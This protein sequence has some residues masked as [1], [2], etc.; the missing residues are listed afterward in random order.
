MHALLLARWQF[1]ITTVYH[2]LFVPL[3][4]GTAFLTA[5]LQTLWLHSGEQRHLRATKFWGRIFL[6]GFVLGV[7]TGIVRQFQLGMAWSGSSRFVGDALGAP[8]AIEGLLA[9]F[10]ESTFL[11]LWVLG[12]DRL[13]RSLHTACIWIAACATALSAY[14]VLAVEG[15][16]RHPVGYTLD[17]ARHVARLTS[18]RAV[19]GNSTVVLA[20]AHTMAAAFLISGMLLVAG[21]AW[22]LRRGRH[23]ETML[24]SLRVGLCSALI[25]GLATAVTGAVDGRIVTDQQPKTAAAA[26]LYRAARPASF[27]LFTVGSING[28]SQ[29]WSIRIPGLFSFL[30]TGSFDGRVEGIDD[31]RTREAVRYAPGVYHPVVPATYWNLRLMIA[32][33]LLATLIAVFG[34][35]HTR[36]KAGRI[37]RARFYRVATWAVL[38]GPIGAG[39]GWIFTAAGRLPWVV[40]G[41]L[42]ARP[43]D[44][45]GGAAGAMWTSL[46][47]LT[48]L[49]A[50]LAA[51]E[52]GLMLRTVRRGPAD[53]PGREAGEGRPEPELGFAY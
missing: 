49:Y 43:G 21:S 34:L 3:T 18:I 20:F 13:P 1:G 41:V 29:G 48:L 11:G 12:W 45:P 46:I 37:G 39:L 52:V 15:W 26:A 47:V 32:F 24:P 16:M 14:F 22:H 31:I 38:L 25:G 17:P 4:I 10:L 28:T 36:A 53:L 42:G 9:F 30:A 44:A 33:G 5:I 35:W 8:L 23:H 50:L 19:L 40:D 6:I 2:F 7:A 27:S 51:V